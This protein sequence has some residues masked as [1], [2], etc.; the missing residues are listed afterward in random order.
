MLDTERQLAERLRAA[1]AEAEALLVRARVN[2]AQREA[3]LAAELELD[4]RSLTERLIGEREKHEREIADDA[5]RR[6]SAYADVSDE[7]MTALARA[8]ARRLLDDETVP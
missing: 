4:E 1:R 2:A 5:Q 8:L 3:K 7:R 6:L